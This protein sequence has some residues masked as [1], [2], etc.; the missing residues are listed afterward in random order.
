MNRLFDALQFSMLLFNFRCSVYS[1]PTIRVVNRNGKWVTC[2]NRRLWV[3]RY[4]ERLGKVDK[5]PVK[6][7]S[8]VP[9]KKLT[10]VNGGTQIAVRGNPGGYCYNQLSRFNDQSKPIAF[11]YGRNCDGPG[12]VLSV[13]NRATFS[14]NSSHAPQ[15]KV[16]QAFHYSG[17]NNI[18][19]MSPQ[20]WNSMKMYGNN[21]KEF[22][23]RTSENN[24]TQRS[25]NVNVADSYAKQIL[26]RSK[27]IIDT[28]SHRKSSGCTKNIF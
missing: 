24:V 3:F 4:L 2:D 12:S 20:P 18:A 9:S 21:R 11:E 14:Q 26:D 6:I 17:F 19:Q 22:G 5:V 7:K 8:D 1:I 25:E 16:C 13:S 28:P 15:H 27:E 10:S 23:F